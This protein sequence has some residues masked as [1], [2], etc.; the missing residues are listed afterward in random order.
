MR[1]AK[2]SNSSAHWVACEP[3]DHVVL[4]AF[5][6]SLFGFRCLFWAGVIVA[7][8][9]AAKQVAQTDMNTV[10]VAAVKSLGRESRVILAQLDGVVLDLR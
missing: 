4:G 10:L 7:P 9:L 5:A 6:A 1:T 2:Q 8:S 3:L